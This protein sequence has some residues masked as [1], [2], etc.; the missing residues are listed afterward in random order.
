MDLADRVQR[1]RLLLVTL[2]DPYPTPRGALEPDSGPAASRYVPC[3]T[4]RS[5]GEVRTR[6]GWSLCLVCD[7]EGWKR[8]EDEPAWDAYVELPL[9]EAVALPAVTVVR[10]APPPEVEAQTYG[11]ERARR[12]YDRHGSYRQLRLQLDWLAL[13]DARRHRL[14]RSV[15]VDQE[16]RVLTPVMQTQLDLGVV[17]IARRMPTV[18]VPPWLIERTAAEE[19][20]ETIAELAASGMSAAVIARRL[21]ISKESARRKLKRKG[22]GSRAAGAPARAA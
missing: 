8:R 15:L 4:C 16:P 6:G 17:M 14:V 3:E 13:V 5:R 19:Q 9:V 1:V 22:V 11:W 10:A 21:G 12:A 7:G 18:K 20:R 2:N